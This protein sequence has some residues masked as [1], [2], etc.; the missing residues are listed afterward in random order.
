MQGI[1]TKL[2]MAFMFVFPINKSFFTMPVYFFSSFSTSSSPLLLTKHWVK[3]EIGHWVEFTGLSIGQAT[4][5]G[6]E[7]I[8][9]LDTKGSTGRI[10]VLDTE[11]V[12]TQGSSSRDQPLAALG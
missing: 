12:R 9:K 7:G 2:L 5:L 4:R 10:I 1:T 3:Y 8:T 11:W 6:I